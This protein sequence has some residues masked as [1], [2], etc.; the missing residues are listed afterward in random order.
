MVI[1]LNIE[2]EIEIEIYKNMNIVLILYDEQSEYK[3]Y[4]CVYIIC[5]VTYF[6]ILEANTFF[7]INEFINGVDQ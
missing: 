3:W 5:V 1:N 4:I 7:Q 2:I 6:E